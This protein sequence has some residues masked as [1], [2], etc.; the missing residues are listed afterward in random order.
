MVPQ[1][2]GVTTQ[3]LV[4][5]AVIAPDPD[6]V[7]ITTTTPTST[8]VINPEAFSTATQV[9]TT[10][11][12]GPVRATSVRDPSFVTSSAPV[13]VCPTGY[14]RCSA[15][16]LG[17]CCQ[18]GQDCQSTDCPSMASTPVATNGDDVTVYV[19]NG[20]GVTTISAGNDPVTTT[21]GTGVTV[22]QITSSNVPAAAVGAGG[23]PQSWYACGSDAG[24]GCCPSGYGCAATCSATQTGLPDTVQKVAP[25]NGAVNSNGLEYWMIALAGMLGIGMVWL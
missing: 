25:S 11:I 9:I 23:C 21:V 17:G 16:Y 8:V 20:Q 24:G 19:G 18:V 3:T 14:Y 7:Y 1:T 2:V 13:G 22:A 6:T 5:T 4:S 10:T 15:Y 12:I